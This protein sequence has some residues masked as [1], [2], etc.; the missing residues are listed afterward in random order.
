MVIE[1]A[2]DLGHVSFRRLS[3]PEGEATFLDKAGLIGADSEVQSAAKPPQ[4]CEHDLGIG[5]QFQNGLIQALL[6]LEL[7]AGDLVRQSG[8]VQL[9]EERQ[10]QS[11]TR[12]AGSLVG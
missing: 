12:R 8:P 5:R 11:R 3:H 7:A 4:R 2:H 10:R 1:T 6:D 9:I